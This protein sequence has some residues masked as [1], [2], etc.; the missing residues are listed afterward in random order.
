VL[1]YYIDEIIT[2]PRY[3][4]GIALKEKDRD[5]TPELEFLKLLTEHGAVIGKEKRNGWTY[6]YEQAKAK[7]NV[8]LM[9]CLTEKYE[10]YLK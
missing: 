8:R 2:P 5:F 3:E 9:K 10:N 6:L 1:K 7:N 4:F